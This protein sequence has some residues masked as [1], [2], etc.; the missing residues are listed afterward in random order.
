MDVRPTPDGLLVN[1]KV[2]PNSDRFF[3]HEDGTI[4]VKS[5]PQ[6]GK[7]NRE[8][9]KEHIREHHLAVWV[10]CPVDPKTRLKKT[11]LGEQQDKMT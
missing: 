5:S 10:I 7:A 8:L 1:V 11:S 9:L 3:F 6:E 4:E 2:K